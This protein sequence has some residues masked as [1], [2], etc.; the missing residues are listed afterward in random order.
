MSACVRLERC[1][2]Q[3]TPP[4]LI[5]NLDDYRAEVLAEEAARPV[6]LRKTGYLVVQPLGDRFLVESFAVVGEDC[7]PV[8]DTVED[9]TELAEVILR[10][11]GR[12]GGA[13]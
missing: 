10:H 13:R 3:P 1:C 7:V 8:N 2:G 4:E 5:A 9:A 12:L 6:R 11:F